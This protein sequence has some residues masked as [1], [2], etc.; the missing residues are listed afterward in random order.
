MNAPAPTVDPSKEA[1]SDERGMPNFGIDLRRIWAAIYR[2]RFVVA[3]IMALALAAAIVL[4]IITTPVFSARVSLQ[5]DSSTTEVLE[6]ETTFRALDWDVDRFLQTQIDVL[7]SKGTAL[8]LIEDMD[9]ARDDTFFERMQVPAPQ[10][11]APGKTMAETRL[12]AIASVLQS[13]VYADLPRYSRILEL[14]YLSPDSE[15]AAQIANGYA[16]AFIASNLERRFDS[17][18][19]AREYLTEQLAE[20]KQALEEAERAQVEYARANNLV[21]LQSDSDDESPGSLTQR[22]L[23]SANDALGEARSRR[24][25]LEERYRA[26]QRG[27]PLAVPEAQN[28][29]YIIELQREL[30]EAEGQISQNAT[31]YRED[32][33]VMLEQRRRAAA[34]RADLENAVANVRGSLRQ[35]Y[36]TAARNERRL[37]ADVAQLRGAT[38]SEQAARVQYNILARETSTRRDMYDALL[39]RFQEVSASA[40]I[41]NS[42]IAIIDPADVPRAPVRPTPIVNIALGLLLGAAIAG[43]YVF[44]REFVDDAAR[45]PDD[46]VERF[47]LP[48]LGS[49]PK[50]EKKTGIA[51]TLD[52]PKSSASEAFAALRTSLG[53]LG[54]DGVKDVLITS[55]QQSEGKSFVAYGIAR[56]FA[57]EGR[58]VL[59]VD[60]DLRRPS[61]HSMFG[62][63]REVGLTNILTRQ[64]APA[65]AIQN[66]LEN[67]D[68]VP[69]GPLPPSVPE[70]F[71]GP[72]FVEFRN[73]AREKYDI[74]IFDGPPVM[75]LA[76]TVLLG[77]KIEHLIFMVEAGLASQGRMAAAIRRLRNNEVEIDGAVLNKFDPHSAGYGYEYG[78]YYSYE[79]ETA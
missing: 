22:T 65:E 56:S 27:D 54:P 76:D 42:N 46:V 40:G 11:A 7:L 49:V 64:V 36:E 18:S 72:S 53:L 43:V 55:S 33:P 67:I 41:T 21:N 16:E 45:T 63:S 26:A 61:Q 20:A 28:N 60:A 75:G 47:G 32:H 3:G 37:A 48:F 39:S 9:L 10:T 58:K 19:Y 6:E 66:V 14:S 52:N 5:I 71:T 34:L 73:W 44:I 77:Q 57:R 38:A 25:L 59:V 70:Y 13:N 78:Y 62:V 2:H 17:S 15:Y 74:V 31:R 8:K 30:A 1:F 29:A 35:Q 79:A 24:L 12:D 68:L 51:A 4:T 23:V 69:S 50:L